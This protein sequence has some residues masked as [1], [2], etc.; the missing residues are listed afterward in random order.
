MKT[1]IENRND[2]ILLVDTFYKEVQQNN[3]IGPIFTE[4]A[5]VDWS[6]HLPKMYDFWES[7]SPCGIKPI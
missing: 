2:L 6:H 5:K 3:T 1:D 4:T 7:I